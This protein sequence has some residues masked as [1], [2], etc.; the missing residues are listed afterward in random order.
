MASDWCSGLASVH[1]T[2]S[3]FNAFNSHPGKHH[4]SPF[5]LSP[6][7]LRHIMVSKQTTLGCLVN[8]DDVDLLRCCCP[9]MVQLL[10][11]LFEPLVINRAKRAQTA[12]CDL[13]ELLAAARQGLL[14]AAARFDAARV[15]GGKG[16]LYAL[17]DRYISTALR[18][19]LQEVGWLHC[20]H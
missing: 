9:C 10:L 1:Q 4:H 13:R 11:Q 15:A 19:V 7:H 20:C 12:G 5:R 6:F 2:L 3:F 18:D 16:R 14:R 8:L 17:A